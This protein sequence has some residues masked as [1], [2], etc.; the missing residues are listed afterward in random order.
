MLRDGARRH[1]LRAGIAR[2]RGRQ[3]G[4]PVDRGAQHDRPVP[5]SQQRRGRG[6]QLQLPLDGLPGGVRRPAQQPWL[7]PR[8]V[9]GARLRRPDG[10]GLAWPAGRDAAAGVRDGAEPPVP[11]RDR[12]RNG[13]RLAAAQRLR[14][15]LVGGA[16]VDPIFPPSSLRHC[17]TPVPVPAAVL[18]DA[19]SCGALLRTRVE[20]VGALT[21]TTALMVRSRASA[22]RLEPWPTLNQ[23]DA[24]V[25]CLIAG[26]R[27]SP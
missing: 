12:D 19:R 15:K 13:A 21:P 27:R 3:G 4:L 25:S 9:G 16:D 2:R 20:V 8:D 26:D 5:G 10:V 7:S 23:T 1:E 24:P 6:G 14:G 17:V 22:R 11:E 18:R